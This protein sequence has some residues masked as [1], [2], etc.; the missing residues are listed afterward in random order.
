[1]ESQK[2]INFIIVCAVNGFFTLAGIFLNSVV[3]ISLWK[4]SQLRKGT[5]NFMILVLSVF[6][7]LA[8]LIGHPSVILNAVSWSTGNLSHWSN[9]GSYGFH[10]AEAVRIVSHHSKSS[11]TA[12]L[13]AMTVDRYLAITRPFFHKTYATK[14]RLLMIAVT[15]QLTISVFLTF[16][17]SKHLKVFYYPTG[18]VIFIMQMVSLFVMNYRIFRIAAR[19]KRKKQSS[20]TQSAHSKKN[21]TC[22]LAVACW[23][24]CAVPLIGYTVI[25]LAATD[26]LSADNMALLRLWVNTGLTL[27]STCNCVIFFWRNETL[28]K[29]GK[30]L[31]SS[32]LNPKNNV[33]YS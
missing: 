30:K 16:R 25:I 18:F 23:Y 24:V 3:I 7:L 14:R 19:A 32:C 1:M 29:A 6:D 15:I 28:R 12:A 9:P 21:F 26:L 20:K 11:S 4:S 33:L 10:I 13:L 5:G 8:I 27:N 22:L 31:L 17:F 2:L